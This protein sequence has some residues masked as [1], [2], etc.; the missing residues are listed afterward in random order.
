M[1]RSQGSKGF[2]LIELL[3]VIAIIAVLAAI[4]FP[5]FAQAREK[6]RMSS[7]M[8]NQRQIATALLIYAQDNT[9]AFPPA[10]T[11]WASLTLPNGVKY[12]P[13][14]T[15][16]NSQRQPVVG[17]GLNY[18]ML[19]AGTTQQSIIDPTAAVL[20]ADC[21]T[22]DNMLHSSADVY[23]RHGNL[24]TAVVS[25]VDGHVTSTTSSVAVVPG[26]PFSGVDSIRMWFR[27]DDPA[28]FVMNNG[29][30]ST[31]YDLCGNNATQGT[32]ANQ[33]VYQSSV[34]ALGGKPAVY[35]DG[36]G[37]STG[38]W[39]NTSNI[40]ASIPWP[41]KYKSG[42][43]TGSIFVVWAVSS[44]TNAYD[45][46][47]QANAQK[48]KTSDASGNNYTSLFMNN[49]TDQWVS[50][51]IPVSGPVVWGITAGT[52]NN[53][54]KMYLFG[55]QVQFYNGYLNASQFTPPTSYRINGGDSLSNCNGNMNGWVAEI[56]VF[57][58]ELT[59]DQ[60]SKLSTYLMHKYHLS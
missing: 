31:W 3:V 21:K 39:M 4:L 12:C 38:Q 16:K 50:G 10:T 43:Q 11:A 14:N 37:T 19:S 27:A 30:I 60:V 24:S 5:V 47:W 36:T 52:A 53:D 40:C 6:A 59:S 45:V 22:A 13:S 32:T 2:T 26:Y 15:I 28:T 41:G 9:G 18:P 48:E 49:W 42:N 51:K 55:S 1:Q 17:Y 29:K 58:S 23:Y 20:T 57:T 56:M 35:F 46:V 33:P 44:V 54:Y 25:F 8:N 7:C 34:A